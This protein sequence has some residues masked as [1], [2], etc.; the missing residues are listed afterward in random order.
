MEVLMV[1]GRQGKATNDLRKVKTVLFVGTHVWDE[2]R[3]RS[4][5]VKPYVISANVHVQKRGKF[6]L[7]ADSCYRWYYGHY[8]LFNGIDFWKGACPYY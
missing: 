3:S 8:N 6:C 1:V 4:C 5:G 2:L 7:S